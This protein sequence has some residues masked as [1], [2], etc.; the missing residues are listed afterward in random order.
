[1][2]GTPARRGWPRSLFYRNLLLFAG[3]MLVGQLATALLFRQLVIKPRVES[4]AH[5]TA[6]KAAVVDRVLSQLRPGGLV[7]LALAGNAR[8]FFLVRDI[9]FLLAGVEAAFGD[10]RV[11][12]Q[13]DHRTQRRHALR[14]AVRSP[15]WSRR[16]C[17]KRRSLL[18]AWT[19]P[20][21]PN[22]CRPKPL[23]TKAWRW[24]RCRCA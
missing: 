17:T 10:H 5:D 11:R 12:A 4:T 13:G 18:Q 6:T 21:T 19:T 15:H 8:V 24:M 1:M 2:S 14:C 7:L 20:V 16:R 3:L 22:C 9:D 23:P